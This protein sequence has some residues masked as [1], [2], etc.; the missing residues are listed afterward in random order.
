MFELEMGGVVL[1]HQGVVIMGVSG[2]T[3]ATD[4]SMRYAEGDGQWVIDPSMT[5][6]T[7]RRCW[8]PEAP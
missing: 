6:L 3:G 5:W 1:K 4:E 2:H 7:T 8:S